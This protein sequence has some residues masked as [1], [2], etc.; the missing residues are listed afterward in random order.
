MIVRREFG[1]SLLGSVFKFDLGWFS[2][3]PWSLFR[4]IVFESFGGYM[5]VFQI[6][7]AKLLIQ[8]GVDGWERKYWL[9]VLPLLLIALLN[10]KEKHNAKI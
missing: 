1:V 2:G 8:F 9:F 3:E 10:H 7:V 5:C 4:L 6:Q